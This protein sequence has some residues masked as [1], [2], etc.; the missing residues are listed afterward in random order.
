MFHKSIRIQQKPPLSF[1]AYVSYT[2]I[3]IVSVLCAS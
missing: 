1:I 3:G 2:K